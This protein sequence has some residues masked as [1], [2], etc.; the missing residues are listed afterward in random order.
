MS[1]LRLS[2]K[3]LSATVC[4]GLASAHNVSRPV[5][6]Q[7]NGSWKFS[8]SF[9]ESRAG[10][11]LAVILPPGLNGSIG[12]SGAGKSTVGRAL[13]SLIDPPG[14]VSG[15]RIVFE[16]QDI[17]GLS[18]EQREV[19]ILHFRPATAEPGQRIIRAGDEADLVYFISSGEVEVCVGSRRIKLGPGD[20]FGEM[21]IISGQPRSAD[22]TA[23]DYSQ[24][25]T[26]SQRDFRQFLRR[27][28]IIREQIAALAAERG[29]MNRQFLEQ[30]A[31]GDASSS[32]EP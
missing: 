23:L 2:A 18:P 4:A 27:Y 29:D 11:T 28:P 30:A 26:L 7:F 17:L 31:S 3:V 5:L 13:I 15:G 16:G 25:A 12:E 32:A 21:A 14:Y 1:G 19:L 20:Y 9:S 10:A 8:V 6:V 24:F 22:V